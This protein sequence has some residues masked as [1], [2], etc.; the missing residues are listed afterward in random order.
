MVPALSANPAAGPTNPVVIVVPT[1]LQPTDQ[2][3]FQQAVAAQENGQ[4]ARAVQIHLDLLQ[5]HP[6][7]RFGPEALH[8]IAECYRALGRFADARAT[9]QLSRQLHPQGAWLHAG[10]LLD[11]E[12]RAADGQWKEAIP[13]LREAAASK[14]PA[15][16]N[17]ARFLLIL[18]HENT[19]TLA[20]ARPV[21]S[22]LAA[23]STDNPHQ[24]YARLKLA[25][26]ESSAG[27][28]TEALVLY[29][30]VLARTG[31]AAL[32][33]EAAVR[34]G[35]LVYNTGQ[36]REAIGFFEVVRKLEAPPFWKQLAHLGLIQ[37]HFALK[38][39]ASLLRIYQEVRPAF[40]DSA[41]PRVLFLAAESYRA[42]GKQGE[43]LT[44]Y[45]T[46]LRD[47]PR[48]AVAEPSAWARLLLLEQ[49]ADAR[50]LHETAAFLVRFP[51]S[52]KIPF[53]KLMRANAFYA[54]GDSKAAL[55]MFTEL[56]TDP[57]ILALDPATLA[58]FH[59]R[60][61][62]SAFLQ[63]QFSTAD[64]ALGGFIQRA[65]A[66]S[67]SLASALWM[68]GRARLELKK[69]EDAL[70][71]LTRLVDHHPN[72]EQHEEA[73]WQTAL[74]AGRLG[75]APLHRQRLTQVIATYPRS[76]RLALAHQLLALSWQQEKDGASRAA[77]HWEEARKLDP[78]THF[79][80]ATQQLI[81]HALTIQ[82]IDR[83]VRET[84]LYD[85]WR[86][87]N[88]KA[89]AL[90]LDVIEWMA[91][92]LASGRD[93]ARAESYYRR[94]LA[95]TNQ[96]AQRQRSQLQLCLLLNKLENWTAAVRE[97]KSYRINFPSEAN[98]SAVLEPLTRALIGAGSLDEATRYAEQILQQ[99]PEGEYNA[100]GR[101]LL[102][103][104][105]TARQDHAEAA[106][107]YAAVAL[108]IDDPVLTPL[109]RRKAEEAR[110]LSNKSTTTPR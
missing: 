37:S 47:F 91:Q 14:T 57:A 64:T 34:A 97:W 79:E 41:R 7:T 13:A 95:S 48:D 8:R 32:R 17:R 62:H 103:D 25:G 39:H 69:F 19:G 83:L 44:Q 75:D 76:A 24:D 98:R 58:S 15:L 105:A 99:N 36:F 96:P 71:V 85:E 26:L 16:R 78:S 82:D 109:A 89:P 1:D 108:L 100:R 70:P 80:Q 40:P 4:H 102:G 33:A 74:L 6:G 22:A 72:F 2:E 35:Q 60:W 59:L 110:K 90:S 38:D 52:P 66:A 67:P 9:L 45:E 73:L 5:F 30:A 77:P 56:S 20:E 43:A 27:R 18:A 12:M 28:D 21:L 107:I 55:P 51:K 49:T 86:R 46:I 10:W 92:E 23:E 29:K 50:H 104:I 31:D 53:V 11:G 93:A 42:S 106:K 65:P 61:G 81:R 94:V 54:S 88:P 101:L 3:L 84:D 68:Q 87:L 63:K